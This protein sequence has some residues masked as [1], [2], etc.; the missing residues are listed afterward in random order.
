MI[1][2][3]G[4]NSNF[5]DENATELEVNLGATAFNGDIATL[6]FLLE[7]GVN[8]NLRYGNSQTLAMMILLNRPIL[9]MIRPDLAREMLTVLVGTP[10]FDPNI[11]NDKGE[12]LLFFAISQCDIAIIN[13]LLNFPGID[14]NVVNLAG[15]TLLHSLIRHGAHHSEYGRTIIEKIVN[16]P[17]FLLES[18]EVKDRRGQTA[19]DCLKM[20]MHCETLCCQELERAIQRKEDAFAQR[21]TPEQ[22]LCDAI[23]DINLEAVREMLQGNPS[24]NVDWQ[25][26]EGRTLLMHAVVTGDFE[27]I[28]TFVELCPTIDLSLADRTRKTALSYA[29]DNRDDRVIKILKKAAKSSKQLHKVPRKNPEAAQDTIGQ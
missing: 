6:S 20:F 16:H 13:L 3:G 9:N 2:H 11:R 25:D 14:I 4:V 26:S 28:K 21:D 15:E 1:P 24:I 22:R 8:P 12:T 23:V 29:K 17:R 27:L 7:S 18:F 5:H 10:K 19:K